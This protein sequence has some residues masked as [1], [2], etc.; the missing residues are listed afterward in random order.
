MKTLIKALVIMPLA[1]V[2]I[3]LSVANRSPVVMSLDPFSGSAPLIAISSPLF[4]II[5]GA[6]AL[7]VLLG[8]FVVWW[9][10]GRYRR[11]LR[12]QTHELERLQVDQALQRSAASYATHGFAGNGALLPVRTNAY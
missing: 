8:G 2:I 9:S 11:A 12:R 10:Q 7:G 3:L 6:V 1:L 4:V 5:L